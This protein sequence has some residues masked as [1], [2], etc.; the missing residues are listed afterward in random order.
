MPLNYESMESAK[1]DRRDDLP[2]LSRRAIEEM[3]AAG[4]SVFIMD[5]RVLRV[6]T[7]IKYHPGGHKP[8]QHMVGKD[9][10]DEVVA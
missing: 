4:N 6:D 8:I 2:V 3:I 10:T 7:W 1:H 9:A 5:K